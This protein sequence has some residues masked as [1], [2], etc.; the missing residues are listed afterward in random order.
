M[1]THHASISFDYSAAVLHLQSNWVIMW[2]RHPVAGASNFRSTLVQLPVFDLSYVL[3]M[4][5]VE[6]KCTKVHKGA[7]HFCGQ[8]SHVL[9]RL[10]GKCRWCQI[11][12]FEM[13][14]GQMFLEKVYGSACEH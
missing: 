5:D 4:C 1:L 2:V 9:D 8:F 6:Q 14:F 12:Q 13:I 11:R 10:R 7:S 3:K